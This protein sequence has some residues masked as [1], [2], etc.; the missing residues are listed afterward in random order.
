[1]PGIIGQS[2]TLVPT[3]DFHPR[4]WISLLQPHTART[5]FV[6]LS[7]QYLSTLTSGHLDV[8]PSTLSGELERVEWSDG[9][10]ET[11]Q[12]NGTRSAQVDPVE[13]SIAEAIEQ[14]GGAVCP[15]LDN[16]CPIDAT[17]VNF[18]HSLKCTTVE[19]VLT[20]LKSS[21]R[22]LATIDGSKPAELVLRK[23]INID[24]RMQFRLFVRDKN[25]IGVSH[26]GPDVAVQFD[27]NQADDIVREVNTWFVTN[28]RPIFHFANDYVLDIYLQR[29]DRIRLIDISLWRCADALLFTWDEL[30][31][32]EWMTVTRRAQFRSVNDT[33]LLPAPTMYHGVPL[34]LRGDR[35]S[36]SLVD[37]AERL[38]RMQENLVDED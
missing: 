31:G 11:I 14:L 1:M 5:L 18:D 19:D 29:P 12:S 22:V 30:D 25:L 38:V 20:M 9:T 32:A 7:P 34:E 13:S 16:V 28:I 2:P 37:V 27:D 26:R 33:R 21:E 35:S 17:W 3:T 6:H 36:S 23:W 24:P 15:K 10:V 8:T 4:D